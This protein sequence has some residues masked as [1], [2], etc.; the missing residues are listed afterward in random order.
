M[1]YL[2]PPDVPEERD[3]RALLIPASTDWLALFGGALTELSLRWNWEQEGITVDQALAVVAEVINGFYAGCMD[4]GCTVEGGYRVI[5]INE[6]G[7]IEEWDG[8]EWTPG[9]GDYALPLPDP[10]TGG[11]ADEQICLAAANAVNVLHELYDNIS[12]SF[13]AGLTEA[14]ALASLIALIIELIGVEVAPIAFAVA[15]FFLAVFSLLFSAL[16]Y[17]FADLWDDDFERQMKCFLVDCAS[18]DAGVV[19]FDWDC[20]NE[21]LNSL[22]NDFGLSEVQLRLYI[23]VGYLLYFIGGGSALDLAGRTTAITSADCDCAVFH[24]HY[25]DFLVD[26]GGFSPPFP[27]IPTYASSWSLGVGWTPTHSGTDGISGISL[28]FTEPIVINS[29][30]LHWTGSGGGSSPFD[31]IGFQFFL[32]GT[33]VATFNSGSSQA[34]GCLNDPVGGYTAD[35]I[36]I[37][38]NT[39]WDAGTFAFTGMLIA[40]SAESAVLGPDNCAEE[41]TCP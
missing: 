38:G 26:D 19:T 16:S 10:R 24:C 34:D 37:G 18:N 31:S 33:V 29:A 28:T 41:P 4:S 1:P 36:A 25:F 22:A 21:H 12:E 9:T 27:G 5:R 11:T 23:Q 3:C 35:Q 13:N 2:T 6:H 14:A 40:Y 39:I 32:A 15:Q 17:L 7:E 30:T 20:F 8:D